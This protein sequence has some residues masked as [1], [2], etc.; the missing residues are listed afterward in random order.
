VPVL[1]AGHCGS[2]VFGRLVQAGFDPKDILHID[3][4]VGFGGAEYNN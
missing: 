2:I 1:G 3:N 4:N